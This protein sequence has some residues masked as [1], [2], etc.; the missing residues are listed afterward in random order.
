MAL[1]FI[2]GLAVGAGAV[3]AY[4]KSDKIKQKVDSLFNKSKD[5]ASKG[6]EKVDDVKDTINATAQC[7]KKK[8]EE[9]SLKEV[10]EDKGK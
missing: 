7:I 8:K 5:I 10:I 4:N 1:P 3:F 6:K 2:A 9:E